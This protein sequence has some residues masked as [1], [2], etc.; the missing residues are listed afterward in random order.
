[1]ELLEN[2]CSRKYCMPGEH[3]GLALTHAA[4]CERVISWK[5]VTALTLRAVYTCTHPS[6][7]HK[8]GISCKYS[9]L[10]CCPGIYINKWFLFYLCIDGVVQRVRLQYSFHHELQ[11]KDT[12]SLVSECSTFTTK[13]CLPEEFPVPPLAVDGVRIHVHTICITFQRN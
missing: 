1:M 9:M 10:Q 13:L 2:Y 4:R 6:L 7:L 8:R 3:A 11:K 5:L 12:Y